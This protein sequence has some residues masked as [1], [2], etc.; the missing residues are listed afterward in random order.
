MLFTKTLVKRTL[1]WDF[2]TQSELIASVDYI[3]DLEDLEDFA[4]QLMILYES[5][6]KFRVTQTQQA[7]DVRAIELTKTSYSPLSSYVF[8][9]Y[10]SQRNQIYA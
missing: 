7:F 5:K 8:T 3:L 10:T 9:G 6:I 2:D 1:S 4:V